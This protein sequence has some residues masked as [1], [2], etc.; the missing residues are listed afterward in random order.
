MNE[1]EKRFVQSIQNKIKQYEIP[2]T[3]Y[4]ALSIA[5]DRFV[6]TQY[7]DK[8]TELVDARIEYELCRRS[9]FYF[10][11][12]Y[13]FIHFPGLGVIPYNLYYFQ[14]EILK[15]T[16]WFKKLV[17][18]KS[19]QAGISTLFSLYSFWLG[20]FHE[21]ENI[22]VVSIKQKKAQAFTKKMFP[23][24][25]RLPQFLKSQIVK[26]N[27]AEI[28]WANG[29]YMLSES[30]SDKAGRG[31]SLSF[32][33]LDELAFYRSDTLTRGII[34]AAQPTLTRTGGKQALISCVTKDTYVF[35]NKGMMQMQDFITEETTPGFN[36]VPLFRIDGLA[37]SQICNLF[38]DSGRN[39][40]I[41][42]KTK[43]GYEVE[44]TE[45]H[46]VL[47]RF[48]D[49][50]CKWKR[51]RAIEKNDQILLKDTIQ[52]FG[53]NEYFASKKITKPIAYTLGNIIINGKLN[54]KEDTIVLPYK[55]KEKR[56]LKRFCKK[57]CHSFNSK[58]IRKDEEILLR[59]E[60][61]VEKLRISGLFSHKIPKELLQMNEKLTKSFIE[62]LGFTKNLQGIR[63]NKEEI[64][65]QIQLLML[66]LGVI[67]RRTD[68]TLTIV[69]EYDLKIK[70]YFIDE[71]KK[72]EKF[73]DKPV[74]DF[75]IPKTNTFLS[76]GIVSHNTPNGMSGAGSYYAE[77]VHQLQILGGETKTDKL[78]TID[79]FEIP[80]LK[81]I[82]PYKGYNDTLNKFIKKGY[83]RDNTVKQEMRKYFKPIADKPNENDFLRKQYDDLGPILY[84]QEIEHDFVV[85]GDQV[86]PEEVLDG[87][88]NKVAEPVSKNMLGKTRVN[89]LNIWKYPVPKKRYIIGV[90]VSSST[91]REYS[92]VQVMDVESY[93]Q[94]AEYKGQV[95]TK[96]FGKLVKKLARYYNEAFTVIE[97]NSIGEAVFNEVYYSEE[98]PYTNVYKQKKTGKNGS[99]RMTGWETNVKTRQLMIN[100]LIDYFTVDDLFAV[101]KVYSDRLYKEMLSFV[102]ING[103][104][105]HSTG[106]AYD[107][108][109]VAFALCLY[110]RNKAN[111]VGESF[112]ISED[113]D[114]IGT[115]DTKEIDEV[116]LKENSFDEVAFSDNDEKTFEEEFGMSPE[117]YN[118]LI[119]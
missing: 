39:K 70:D 47:T 49:G 56:K 89:G 59:S 4:E 74:Y 23:T 84:R 115:D 3:L 62:G 20:N 26:R 2:I 98:D 52:S 92:A 108:A 94:V 53:N 67:I 9:P 18:L 71:V 85:S 91:G 40:T 64:L 107:D 6:E 54:E 63:N 68:H 25:D 38:Y 37:N 87:V 103:K 60:E 90:D 106:D 34:S 96:T 79:W 11:S 45:I 73:E 111:T 24:M 31:D 118:W 12:K 55:G 76:N 57:F 29:S 116:K 51:L 10:I 119:G 36:P 7:N 86:F 82:K 13:G 50:E 65:K 83:Y 75:Y 27:T 114:F 58:I 77:Q 95:A 44:G 61:M 69:N 102:W 22:D 19:R 16:N 101:L 33:I 110:F 109:L 104:A 41:K 100:N 78:I 15:D 30:A 93:E 35:T 32:L 88:K 113:G 42:I 1:K 43:L 28:E 5:G 48:P 14:K 80:D 99:V 112:L 105:V 72:I 97:C 81:G 117:Q 66:N 8:S 46:P 21:S 17:F